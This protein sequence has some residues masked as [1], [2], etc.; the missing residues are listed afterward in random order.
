M[1]V[2]LMAVVQPK[3]SVGRPHD[4]TAEIWSHGPGRKYAKL[5]V[6]FHSKK[7]MIAGSTCIQQTLSTAPRQKPLRKCRNSRTHIE[8]W[9]WICLPAPVRNPLQPVHT[10][11]LK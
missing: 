5:C 9:H 7:Q 3:Q 8:L 4:N 1:L 10:D 2:Y 6:L 11:K